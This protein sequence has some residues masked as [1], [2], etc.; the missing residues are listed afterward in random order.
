MDEPASFL[1][2]RS[3]VWSSETLE[4]GMAAIAHQSDGT[5]V[6][7]EDDESMAKELAVPKQNMA[8]LILDFE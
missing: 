2:R 7:M 4:Q 8:F 5:L 6:K 3:S 1:R